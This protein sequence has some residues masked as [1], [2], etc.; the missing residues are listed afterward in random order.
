MR[1]ALRKERTKRPLCV[2]ARE[3]SSHLERITAH[4]TTLKAMSTKSTTLATAP[5][6]R[7]RSRISP[8]TKNRRT[9]ETCMGFRDAFSAIIK[10]CG[11]V[12]VQGYRVGKCVLSFIGVCHSPLVV[13]LSN[14]LTVFG[15]IAND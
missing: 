13:G 11:C 6:C 7:T 4:E 5:V 3:I 1:C 2:R 14:R 9:E 8:P 10:Q 12:P 15:G